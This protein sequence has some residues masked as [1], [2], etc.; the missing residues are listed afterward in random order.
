VD[1]LGLGLGLGKRVNPA[2][3]LF[4]EFPLELLLLLLQ[5]VEGS[6]LLVLLLVVVEG[7]EGLGLGLPREGGTKER[8]AMRARYCSP[9]RHMRLC[10][11]RLTHSRVDE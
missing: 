4:K 11:S 1:E 9:S 5:A 8:A 10:T 7:R 6:L 2:R 3:P